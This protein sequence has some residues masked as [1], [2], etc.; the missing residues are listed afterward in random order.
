MKFEVTKGTM[1]MTQEK[2]T[3]QGAPDTLPE[4]FEAFDDARRAGFIAAMEFKQNGGKLAGCLCSYTPL[5]LLDAAG[6]AAVGLCGMSNETVPDA[7]AVL[8]KNLCPLIKG[9]YGFA[10][11]QKCPYTYF[12]DL[13][14]GETTCDGKKKMYELL[15]DI[16][17]TY[18]L[19]LPQSQSRSYAF[20]IWREE[21]ELLKQELERRFDVEITDEAL[22]DAV[23]LR[24]RARRAFNRLYA[25]QENVPPAMSGVEMMTTLLKST[26]SFDVEKF[27][28]SVEALA[29]ARGTAYEAGERPVPASA[30]RIMLTGC[31]SG[32]VIQKVGMTVERNGGAIVCLD[33]CSGERTQSMLI[34]EDADDILRAISDR[35][36]S[37]NCSVMTPNEGRIENSL[38]M[39][40]KYRV[41]GVI[42]VVLQACHTFNVESA[43]VAAACEER[44][45]PYLKIETDYSTGDLGQLETRIAAFI[46]ML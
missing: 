15:N 23:R 16:K 14:I 9:T 19:H 32:G 44:G 17:P 13:I 24:N 6:V 28:E 2:K 35:Y 21:V 8:P 42:E 18:V 5:E 3:P 37:I 12:S 33:D 1:V 29:D 31:P 25:L 43:K 34:D 40:E 20:D 22:R 36:L 27:V 7:E 11:T 10:L 45:I 39:V 38:A 30:K 46:E 41:D 26:F 4:I